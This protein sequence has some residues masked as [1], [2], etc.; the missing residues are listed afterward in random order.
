MSSCCAAAEPPRPP[1]RCRPCLVGLLGLVLAAWPVSQAAVLTDFT[2]QAGTVS[3]ADFELPGGAADRM[4]DRFAQQSGIQVL[5]PTEE[6]RD[7]QTNPVHGRFTPREALEQM[8]AGTA[9]VAEFDGFNGLAAIARARGT[10]TEIVRLPPFVVDSRPLVWHY[11]KLEKFEMLSACTAE[12]TNRAIEQIYRLHEA[13]GLLLP[14]DRQVAAAMPELYIVHSDRSQVSVSDEL[15][16]EFRRLETLQAGVPATESA[17]GWLKRNHGFWDHDGYVVYLKLNEE[18]FFTGSLGLTAD[19]V[20]YVLEH[21]LPG[22]PPWL[23]EGMMELYRS[24]QLDPYGVRVSAFSA[25]PQA[26]KRPGGVVRLAKADALAEALGATGVG[27]RQD[28]IL[29]PLAEMFEQ[30]PPPH[31][32]PRREQWRAQ[33]ALFLRWALDSGARH[34]RW[35]RLWDLVAQAGREPLKEADFRRAFRMGY[36]QAENELRRYL[37]KAQ[38][39]AVELRPVRFAPDLRPELHRASDLEI[40]WVKGDLDR[41]KMRYV[42]RHFPTLTDHYLKLTREALDRAQAQSPED[43]RV[44]GLLGLLACDHGD[45]ATAAPLL[46]AAV[47]G[48]DNRPRVYWELARIRAQELRTR[49]AETLAD[50]AAVAAVVDLLE[51][52]RARSP[53]QPAVYELLAE[54]WQW[55]A[56]TL[57]RSQLAVLQDGLRYF[58]RRLSLIAPVARL[59]ARHGYQVEAQAILVRALQMATDRASRE[60]L[61]SLR[62]EIHLYAGRMDRARLASGAAP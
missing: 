2:R 44:L 45:D 18:G 21:R 59:H 1:I 3:L 6:V 58:P 35:P 33:A 11:A 5:F 19:Y 4:L 61:L 53:A 37:P 15:M 12:A 26:L 32:D 47:A 62:E 36:A 48:R 34:T 23:V 17:G 13:L 14:P 41:L 49:A 51:Q 46:A 9:L 54:V 40:G 10:G 24:V 28:L 8:L 31:G 43:P 38:R 20:R 52:A 57:S 27:R 50:P 60:Q 29:R 55:H 56:I 39:H 30:D 22:S 25:N 7:V 16:V 42:R